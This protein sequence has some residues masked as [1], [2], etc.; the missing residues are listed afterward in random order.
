MGAAIG[1]VVARMSS[2]SGVLALNDDVIITPIADL[3]EELLSQIEHSVGDVAISR[4]RGRGGS[5]IID[6]EF[7]R[8]LQR[9]REPSRVIDAVILHARSF[10]A[11]AMSLFE[12]AYPLLRG[13]VEREVLIDVQRSA[14][15]PT[16]TSDDWTPGTILPMGTVVRSLQR[17]DDGDVLL[18]LRP[19]GQFTVLKAA[20]RGAALDITERLHHEA[21]VLRQLRGD[22]APRLLG[23]GEHDGRTYLA[24][25]HVHGIDVMSAV[26]AW[27][28]RLEDERRGELLR[29][30]GALCD[31]Y[32]RLHERGIL[33]GDVHPGNVMVLRDGSIRLLD[34][35]FA[36]PVGGSPSV[37]QRAERGGVPFFLEPE[38]AR[39]RLAGAAVLAA[40][41]AGEQFSVGALIYTLVTGEYW[42]R[43][44]L[45]K[46]EM[47]HDAASGKAR[48]F[49]G[50]GASPWPEMEA[51]LG[52]A[53]ASMPEERWASMAE[54]ANAIASL[55]QSPGPTNPRTPRSS[56]RLEA[57]DQLLDSLTVEGPVY[58]SQLPAP[59]AS[60]TYGAAG[61]A[62]GLLAVSARWGSST[63]LATADCWAQRAVRE[64]GDAAGFYNEEIEISSEV[65]GECSP[66]HTPSGVHAVDAL[67]GHA[68]GD[69]ARRDGGVMR[70]LDV[71]RRPARGLDLTLGRASTL[72][73][74]AILLDATPPES[75]GAEA[76]R[77]FGDGAMTELWTALNG[78]GTIGATD[79][80]YLGMAHG[81]AGYLYATLQWCAVSGASLPAAVELRADQLAAL[82]RPV[83]RGLEWPW[84]VGPAHAISTMSGWCNGS[85]GY[86]FLWT[87][88]HRMMGKDSYLHA[89]TGAAWHTWEARDPAATLCC[90]LAGRGYALLN[91]YRH[92]ADTEW[93]ARAQALCRR[94][95]TGGSTP[96]EY[97]HSLYKGLLGVTVLAADLAD[98]ES[99][100]MPFFEPPGFR[101]P[102]EMA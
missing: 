20:S 25:E 49:A 23:E 33:H 92:T 89:A 18:I 98:P 72:L 36:S 19:D 67:L 40:T 78:K 47:L 3:P 29:I 100:R 44:R 15:S 75:E 45:G 91:V 62:L 94:A 57:P 11:D 5:S 70:F 54:M 8:L 52:R 6:Q 38:L 101:T 68:S 79:G 64:L 37:P 97:P 81:W 65:V 32:A 71:A 74:A 85:T 2:L 73:G 77:L 82:A 22:P 58:S 95:E 63:L 80:E 42:Q 84:V 96:R 30:A 76:L 56:A 16:R 60:I 48:T 53:L 34:F 83:E 12:S 21:I 43:F 66:Y 10:D 93:V 55:S 39:A 4:G 46:D 1:T 86:V 7:A 59:T 99:A 28:D 13:M 51:I 24:L 61:I 31:T 9:F 41:E 14:H 102:P 35:G 27:R 26:Q 88:A 17:L 50:C 90:G 87:L 69:A